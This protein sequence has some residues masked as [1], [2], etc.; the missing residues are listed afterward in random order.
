MKI[1]IASALLVCADAASAQFITNTAPNL[2]ITSTDRYYGTTPVDPSYG[3]G[4]SGVTPTM[5]RERE[6]R[7]R[8]VDATFPNLRA[9]LATRNP[10]RAR[11]LYAR[12]EKQAIWARIKARESM[13]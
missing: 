2:S 13:D 3:L 7:A 10:R 9:E 4:Y 11:V 5:R 12:A 8:L 1:L 6:A